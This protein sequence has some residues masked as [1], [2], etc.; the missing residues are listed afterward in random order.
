MTQ[1]AIGHNNPPTDAEI[2]AEQFNEK[3]GEAIK[4]A[5]ELIAAVDRMPKEITDHE[6]AKKVTTL[7]AQITKAA[8]GI[9]K[10]RSAEKEPYL[11][12]GRLVDGFFKTFTDKLATAKTYANRPLTK[13]LQDEAEKERKRREEEAERQRK[14]AADKLAEAAAAEQAGNGLTAQETMKEALKTEKAADKLEKSIAGNPAALAQTRTETGNM[15]SLRTAWVGQIIDR[16]ELDL[17][18]LR[19]Y[20]PESALQTAVNA[21]VKDGG[22]TLKGATITQTSTAVA[23]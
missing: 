14:E 22:R 17:E 13:F 6:T 7:I 16:A 11:T 4:H 2:L 19:Q 18:A 20:L 8:G 5:D 3:H 9:D 21:F 12:K 15:A 23:R 1:A 10:I